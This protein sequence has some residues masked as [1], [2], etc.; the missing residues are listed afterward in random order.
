MQQ[1]CS[2]CPEL[3][4]GDLTGQW[5]YGCGGCRHTPRFGVLP[6][7][8]LFKVAGLLRELTNVRAKLGIMLGALLAVGMLWGTHT[9]RLVQLVAHLLPLAPRC[10]IVG[11]LRRTGALSWFCIGCLCLPVL[12]P[13]KL[14]FVNGEN[15]RSA[16]QAETVLRPAPLQLSLV[17]VTCKICQGDQHRRQQ[18]PYW[19][20]QGS[21]CWWLQLYLCFCCWQE[22]GEQ[23]NE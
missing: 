4:P 14:A 15:A 3:R 5:A 13:M 21:L 6:E 16:L 11:V 23:Y 18:W 9:W 8:S 20:L 19:H 2:P 22:P 12:Q 17:S 1:G 7:F 10:A